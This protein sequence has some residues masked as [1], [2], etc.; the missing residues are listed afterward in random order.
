MWIVWIE[1]GEIRNGSMNMP[2][3][4]NTQTVV[5]RITQKSSFK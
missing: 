3:K 2:D 1:V 4:L 5:Q